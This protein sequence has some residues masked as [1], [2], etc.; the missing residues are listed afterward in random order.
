MIGLSW[1]CRGLGNSCTVRVLTDLLRDRKPTFLFL[2]ETISFGNKIEGFRIKYGFDYCFSID[3]EGQSGGLAFLWK[4]Q[5]NCQ[6]TGY[7]RNHIDVVFSENEVQTW[8][9]TCYYGFPERSRRREAWDFI[10]RLSSISSLPWCIWGDFNDLLYVS[11]KEGNIP[12]PPGLLEGFRGAIEDCLA[13]GGG[14]FM[15]KKCRGTKDWVRERLDRAFATATWW[16]KFPLCNLQ[17]V[18]TSRSDHDPIQLDLLHASVSKREFRFRFENTWLKDPSFV[19][20]VTEAWGQFARL[21]LVSKLISIT[22]FMAR[23]GRSFFNKFQ[24]KVKFQKAIIEKLVNRVD[25]RGVEE[26]MKE[27]DKLND[28]LLHQELY[29]KQRAKS[30]WLA[31]GDENT[32]F[33]HASASARRRT[34]RIDFLVND[35]GERVND[36]EGMCD[37]VRNYFSEVF[38]GDNVV[39]GNN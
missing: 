19:K 21:H 35:H 15:W 9:L 23:W 17:V 7:S 11:D 27:R 20:E 6:V 34:N 37:M 25:A 33:F 10:R 39:E 32:R 30:F 18:H 2:C 5:A 12:H 16:S 26:Y 29:W 8:R 38:A 3:R 31:E 24:E 13:L 1:N 28:L 14:K 36:Q 4:K 22:K